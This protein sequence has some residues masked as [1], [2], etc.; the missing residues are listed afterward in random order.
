MFLVVKRDER[1][2]FDTLIP[3][4]ISEVSYR[5][6]LRLELEVSLFFSPP[7]DDVVLQGTHDAMYGF[8]LAK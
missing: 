7:T 5:E 4:E 6:S 1:W 8:P 3:W 2:G